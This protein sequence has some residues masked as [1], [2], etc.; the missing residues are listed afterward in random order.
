[1]EL[2]LWLLSEIIS[3]LQAKKK[4]KQNKKTSERIKKQNFI[5]SSSILWHGKVLHSFKS[6][7]MHFYFFH[8]QDV[9]FIFIACTISS[10]AFFV[11]WI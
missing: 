7:V 10:A 1:M 6:R 5:I 2:E 3:K 11:W 8:Y 4:Q 9:S